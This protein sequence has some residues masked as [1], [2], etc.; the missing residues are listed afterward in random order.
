MVKRYRKKDP[1]LTREAGLYE[2]PVPSRE[3]ILQYLEE[4]ARPVTFRHLLDA[5][6]L[7]KPEKKEGLRRRLNAMER[8]GQCMS[9]RRG[10]YALVKKMDLV[11]GVVQGHRDGFGFLIPDDGNSDI[12]LPAR[13]MR[14]VFSDD[15]VLVRITNP[16]DRRPE[17][18]IVE[19]L[20]HN[21]HQIVGRYYEEEGIAFVDPDNKSISQ[22]IVVPKDQ[23]AN[24]KHGQFVVIEITSQ[25]T[26][27]RHAMGRVIEV[28]GD[29]LT[30]GMEVQLA[31]R[32][33]EIPFKWPDDVLRE[34]K[35]FP[36]E[37]LVT[38]KKDREDLRQLPFVTIDGEDAKDFDDAVFCEPVK[39]GGWNLYVAIADVS[40]YVRIDSA[41]DSE[42]R[43]RGNSVYFPAKVIPMLPETLSNNLCSLKPNVDRLAITCR[44]RIDEEGHVRGHRFTESI[45][46]SHARLTYSE[47]AAMLD[48]KQTKHQKLLPHMKEFHRLY[49]KLQKQRVV[50]G[51]IEF[52]T[53]ETRIEFDK[54]G[55]IKRIVPSVRN[56]AHRMIEE[57][58][59]AANVS[60]AQWLEKENIPILYRIHEGP[61]EQKLLALR[62]FLK[63]FGLRLTGGNKP[64]SMD[65]AK[66]LTR[67]EKRPDAHLLQTVMLR[68]LRQAMY[69]PENVGHF[70]LSYEG[71]CHFTSPIRRYPDLLVHRALKHIL[72]RRAVKK[73]HYDEK[74][75]IELGEHCSMTERRA[76][77]A[78]RDAD[79]WLKCEFMLD[80]IGQEFNGR[81]VEVTGFG[82]FVEL[83]Q[84]YV[85]GLLH[86]TSLQNDYYHHDPTHHLLRGKRSGKIYRLGDPIRVLVSKVD[87]DQ[88]KIDFE[89]AGELSPRKKT[90][91]SDK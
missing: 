19:V 30:P 16:K 75:M 11:R 59:L 44:M 65:Y 26:K 52:E 17:G 8:D 24:A 12:F 23:Q 41:L 1:H 13:E 15:V 48:G 73:F 29:H 25:P 64:T 70:G 49:K 37:L 56:V 63:A 34:A 21:T 31:I 46:H 89:L 76:D 88:R 68:S 36:A 38:D 60:T 84:I 91:P 9:N 85:Q 28:L 32:S 14:S 35:K 7:Q 90:Q 4:V 2:H 62:D 40:H 42:A 33:Y 43:E 66:L 22:D 27:R 74:M 72:H 54:K 71:Y 55:K 58:M 3:F 81:I 69:L 6:D 20:E 45:I 79:D 67:V 82:V 18:S 78:T 87:L 10:S 53:L 80:K 51:A 83:D 61:E 39:T 50:R 77:R 5:F 57:A 47:V 86:I